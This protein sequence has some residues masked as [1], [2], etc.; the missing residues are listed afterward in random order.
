MVIMTHDMF[1]SDCSA[2]SLAVLM[3]AMKQADSLV[4]LQQAFVE[5]TPTL[6][7]VLLNLI[8]HSTFAS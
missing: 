2:S 3:Y 8:T 4:L 1:L 6:K 7:F 5:K